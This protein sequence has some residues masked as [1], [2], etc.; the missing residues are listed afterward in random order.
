M[1]V[2]CRKPHPD[3]TKTEGLVW[4]FVDL[5]FLQKLATL[6][7]G[8]SVDFQNILNRPSNRSL[9]WGMSY[10][11]II[12]ILKKK[13][14]RRGGATLNELLLSLLHGCGI[15]WILE[16]SCEK[17]FFSTLKTI[18][19]PSLRINLHL[20][21]R[22]STLFW[23]PVNTNVPHPWIV[24][25]TLYRVR[26]LENDVLKTGSTQGIQIWSQKLWFLNMIVHFLEIK[27]LK[28]TKSGSSK[29]TWKNKGSK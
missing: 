19:H 3:I 10:F 8:N 15:T 21:Q 4:T 9:W 5:Y 25:C 13:S 22:W 7:T 24:K 20:F 17:M 16:F 6:Q 2:E 18:A 27:N 28:S 11:G 1:W 29:K 26:A 14:Y 12:L 23:S